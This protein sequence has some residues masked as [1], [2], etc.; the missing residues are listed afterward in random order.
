MKTRLEEVKTFVE[1]ATK[2]SVEL[3]KEYGGWYAF[4]NSQGGICVVCDN[5]LNGKIE[6]AKPSRNIKC[7]L[8]IH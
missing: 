7:Q 8:D 3:H 6:F 2:Q 5:I 1:G 4:K